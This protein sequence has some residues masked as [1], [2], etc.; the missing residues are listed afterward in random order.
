MF[1][2]S[3]Y[4]FSFGMAFGMLIFN[5]FLLIFLIYYFDA[6]LPFDDSPRR[7]PFFIFEVSFL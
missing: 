1:E 3:F 4:F 7:K 6:V 2:G 5:C